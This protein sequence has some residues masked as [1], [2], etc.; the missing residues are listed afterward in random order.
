MTSLFNPEGVIKRYQQSKSHHDGL[1]L[2]TWR[3]VRKYCYP[4]YSD[5]LVEGGTRGRYLFDVT[6]VEC[7]QRLAAGMYN[8]M[9]PPDKRWFEIVPGDKD[10]AD[11]EDVKEYFGY[12]TKAISL[13]LANSNWPGALIDA[14][15]NLAC[16]L[17]AVVYVEDQTSKISFKTYP[18]ESVCYTR[19]P[20]GRVDAVFV[21]VEMTAKNLADNGFDLTEEQSCC[22]KDA[23][24]CDQKFKI[25]HAVMPRAKRDRALADNK[26]FPIADYWIDLAT[27]KVL[28]ESGYR[29]MPFAVCSFE[30]SDN[31]L[32]GRGPGLNML[33]TIRMLNRMFE[34]FILATEHN[35][36]FGILAPDGSLIG[37]VD[38]SPGAVITY[39]ADPAGAKPEI[40]RQL[41][42]AQEVYQH[43]LEERKKVEK[44]F[45][46][47]IFNPLG[48]VTTP[49]TATEAQIREANAIVPFAPV[50]GALHQDLFSPVIERVYAILAE[51]GK[52]PDPPAI[53]LERGDY[54]IDFVSKI[55]LSIKNQEAKSWIGISQLLGGLAKT[56]PDTLDNLDLDKVVRDVADALGANPEWLRATKERD[57]IRQ[58]R[59]Q[60]QA[61]ANQINA[62]ATLAPA[63]AQ[64][65]KNPEPGSV[66]AGIMNGQGI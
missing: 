55:A 36:D 59:A 33:P 28:R 57:A 47:D 9:A 23:S 66:L 3:D 24:R 54:K 17:D 29:Q 32:Y 64:L 25:L 16:G 40:L 45:F 49:Y 63:A 26:N 20:F 65:D 6:A 39:K 46:Y 13:A 31:E 61:A 19:D 53:L 51:Q 7:R 41:F 34:A 8:W 27:K 30:R 42:N 22:A 37:T 4:S 52:L 38:K 35:S 62:A 5:F 60:E 50:A 2:S 12:C 14:L 11:N 10:L 56:N 43:I 18:I 44:G 48:D 58:A 21:E 1:W 15:N